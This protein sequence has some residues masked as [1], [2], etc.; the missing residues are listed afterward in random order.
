MP[1]YPDIETFKG[2]FYNNKV[3]NGAN[4][5]EYSAQDLRKPYDA[6][7]TDGIKP[8]AD[9]TVGNVLKV[10]A[11]GK[12]A[13]SVSEGFAKL[14]G[15]PIENYAPYL[16]TLDDATS[17]VRYDC[18][19]LQNDDNDNV[20]K[21]SI[22]IKSLG[23]V[24]TINDLER[25]DTV[26]E[27]CLAYIVVPAFA[28]DIIDSDIVD[29]RDDGSLCNVMSGVGAMVVQTFR[30]A[31]FSETTNQKVIPIGIK[32]FKKARDELTVI[33][34]GRIFSEG[35]NYSI[36]DDESITLAIGLPVIGTKIE[37]EVVKNV[38]AAGA[39]TV[40]LEVQDLLK[41]MALVNHKLEYDYYCNGVNDNV[42]ISNIVKAYLQGGTDYGTKHINVIGTM[43]VTMPISG[44]GTVASPYVWFD[45]NVQSNRKAVVDFSRCT[46]IKPGVANGTYN[47]IFHSEHG[48]SIKNAN[49]VASNTTVNT[50]IR[51]NTALTGAIAFEDCRFWI[52]AY[53]D[54]LIGMRGTYTNC[55]G[56]IA[57]VVSNSYCFL[58]NTN[59]IVRVIGGEYYAYTGESSSKSAVVGQSGADAVCIM[60]G[61]NAPTV[62]RSGF[63]QTDSVIQFVG[64]GIISCTDLISSLPA[65]VT[66]GI[67]NIRGTIVK[68]KP[69]AM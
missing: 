59:S 55:R 63:Y 4:D 46:D 45:F 43:G 44:S 34:E 21:P 15:A 69:G 17:T 68:S 64:G 58:P 28:T 10:T 32:Q 54:S 13:I 27:V 30:N 42:N 24:P 61:V 67:S 31:Y 12:M 47:V 40:V 38:N 19:I 3:R 50:V 56:S 52:T 14:G 11:K 33:I 60:Y 41:D 48:M 22:Y 8:E 39:E 2:Y 37:F 57:N 9:G 53:K 23:H 7:F 49:V 66:A 25:N 18:V 35:T 29:T 5:R 1:T 6:V 65:T 36:N 62:A 26:Y 20:R 51:I 16:I